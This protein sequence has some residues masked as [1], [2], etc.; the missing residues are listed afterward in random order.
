MFRPD[1][2]P[3]DCPL[4]HDVRRI[5]RTDGSGT[6]FVWCRDCGAYDGSAPKPRPPLTP[7]EASLSPFD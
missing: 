3:R 5:Y 4:A 2:D 7:M 6:S 1:L